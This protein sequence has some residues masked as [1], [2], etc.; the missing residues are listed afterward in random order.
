VGKH[1]HQGHNEEKKSIVRNAQH[2]WFTC[3]G[4]SEELYQRN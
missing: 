2:W 4:V 1:I 3:G